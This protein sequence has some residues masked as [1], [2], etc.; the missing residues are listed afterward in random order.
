MDHILDLLGVE[1]KELK[2][3]SKEKKKK[4]SYDRF[5]KVFPKGFF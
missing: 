4:Q 1:T 3:N 5:S 2:I